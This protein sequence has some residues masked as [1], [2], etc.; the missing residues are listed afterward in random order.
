MAQIFL[1]KLLWIC[2]FVSLHSLIKV[3]STAYGRPFGQTIVGL[4]S[5][6]YFAVRLFQLQLG[7]TCFATQCIAPR[8]S[9]GF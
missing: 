5:S 6:F 4:I 2:D 9:T 8:M 3:R 1:F 7:Q